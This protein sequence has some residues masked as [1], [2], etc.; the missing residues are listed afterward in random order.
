MRLKPLVFLNEN[1]SEAVSKDQVNTNGEKTK[2]STIKKGFLTGL[3]DEMNTSQTNDKDISVLTP[4]RHKIF[5]EDTPIEIQNYYGLSLIQRKN[6][7]L[8]F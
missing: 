8:N 4:S 1:S 6:K 7:G 3:L 5:V 2:D